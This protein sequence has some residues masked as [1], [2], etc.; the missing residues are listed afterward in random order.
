[1]EFQTRLKFID[2][3]SRSWYQTI[4]I[5]ESI[6]ELNFES[7]GNMI[8]NLQTNNWGQSNHTGLNILSDDYPVTI[9][10]LATKPS[11]YSNL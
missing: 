8:Q 6:N 1:M 9:K 10:V 7:F 11:N 3:K 4:E 5:I 2:F